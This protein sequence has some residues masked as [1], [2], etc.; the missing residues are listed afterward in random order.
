MKSNR[1]YFIIIMLSALFIL[2]GCS[3]KNPETKEQNTEEKKPSGG[4]LDTMLNINKKAHENV[5]KA[6]DLEN[7]RLNDSLNQTVP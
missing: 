2:S 4:Y 3:K 7:Q 5:K 1:L 6:T